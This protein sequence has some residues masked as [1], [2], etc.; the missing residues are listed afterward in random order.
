MLE[1]VY[2]ERPID[3]GIYGSFAQKPSVVG[4]PW[5][6]EVWKRDLVELPKIVADV[7]KFYAGDHPQ[8]ARFLADHDVRY[9]VWSLRESQ[10]VSEMAVDH[11]VDRKRF[12]LDGIFLQSRFST[13]WSLDPSLITLSEKMIVTQTVTHQ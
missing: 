6:L 9:I 13:C 11:A 10:D 8:M 4:V 1:N 2:D 7:K 3:T 12:P 5:I